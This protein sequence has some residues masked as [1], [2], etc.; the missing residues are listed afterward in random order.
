MHAVF[1]ADIREHPADDA[2]RLVY[3]D[4]LADHGDE[5]RGEL[6]RVQCRRA[7]LPPGHPEERGLLRREGELLAEHG[8][9]WMAELPQLGGITWADFTR[10]F[11]EE[12]FAETG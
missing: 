2:P 5:A 9:R 6:I 7:H 8:A 3:A 12:V 10:G 4:W 11:A 1:L